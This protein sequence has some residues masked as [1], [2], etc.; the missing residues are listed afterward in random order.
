VRGPIVTNGYF[1]NPEATKA[2]FRNGWFATGDIA[3]VRG[4]KFYIV[5]RLKVFSSS[6]SRF[7]HGYVL[8]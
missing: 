2:A 7:E 6:A 4:G 5:D 3:V 1:K 8:Y